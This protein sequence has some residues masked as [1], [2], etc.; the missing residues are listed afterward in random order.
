MG[1]KMT[2]SGDRWDK[3]LNPLPSNLNPPALLA[4]LVCAWVARILTASFKLPLT[5]PRSA[6]MQRG[7]H[8]TTCDSMLGVIVREPFS[9]SLPKGKNTIT[10]PRAHHRGLNL[11][12]LT[13]FV[14]FALA[15]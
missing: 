13:R 1:R 10:G 12:R 11:V 14:L 15:Y 6:A 4:I 2:T 9:E 8:F 5:S 7:K 3:F